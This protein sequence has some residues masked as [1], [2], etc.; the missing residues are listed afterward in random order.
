MAKVRPVFKFWLET[1][2]GY[3]F[4][5]GPFEILSKVRELGT[6]SG[7]AES[8]HMSYRQ[9]WGMIR[10][11]EKEL[12]EPLLE[13][14]KGGAKGGGAKLTGAGLALLEKYSKTKRELEEFSKKVNAEY[15]QPI[16]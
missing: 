10:E 8:L 12:G 4:G 11:I 1:D 6:L 3:A 7:A 9:A 14:H 16:S 5:K 15:S 13:S 2:N